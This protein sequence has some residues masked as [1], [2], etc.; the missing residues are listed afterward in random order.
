MTRYVYHAWSVN[1]RQVVLK[2][3]PTHH[4]R[5]NTAEVGLP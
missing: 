4:G 2:G 3:E 5:V 1:L